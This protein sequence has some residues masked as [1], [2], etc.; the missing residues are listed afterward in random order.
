MAGSSSSWLETA[1]LAKQTMIEEQ[2]DIITHSSETQIAHHFWEPKWFQKRG[3][4]IQLQQDE[5]TATW[6][7]DNA[8]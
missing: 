5:P 6:G 4:I 7:A 1:S 2:H 8:A 3:L